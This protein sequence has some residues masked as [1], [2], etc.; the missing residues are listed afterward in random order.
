MCP[1]LKEDNE[2]AFD[3]C[4]SNFVPWYD[5]DFDGIEDHVDKCPTQKE[6]YNKFQDHDG[7]PDSLDIVYSSKL[8]DTDGDGFDDLSDHCPNQPETFNNILDSDGCPDDYIS[9]VD[10]DM[11]V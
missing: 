6:N 8:T 11:V 1:Y 2:G 10:R 4:P 3:G 5:H 7:C 9:S